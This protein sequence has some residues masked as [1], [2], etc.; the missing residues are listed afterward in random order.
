MTAVGLGDGHVGLPSASTKKRRPI[1]GDRASNGTDSN[2][3]TANA[4]GVMR[5]NTFVAVDVN[6]TNGVSGRS[7]S[8]ASETQSDKPKPPPTPFEELT[9]L[10]DRDIESELDLD[11]LWRK[12]NAVWALQRLP[13]PEGI[14]K[15]TPIG[16]RGQ[17]DIPKNPSPDITERF[18]EVARR[19]PKLRATL[20]SNGTARRLIADPR[21]LRSF[22]DVA[23]GHGNGN[24]SIDDVL[25]TANYEKIAALGDQ[26]NMKALSE[27]L[28][29]LVEVRD[30][31]EKHK[32]G[33]NWTPGCDPLPLEPDQWESERFLALQADEDA[34]DRN[35]I[36]QYMN[37]YGPNADVLGPFVA[38]SLGAFASSYL[39]MTW[40]AWYPFFLVVCFFTYG[41][42]NRASMSPTV[43][44]KGMLSLSGAATVHALMLVSGFQFFGVYVGEQWGTRMFWCLVGTAA[45]ATTEYFFLMTYL[46]GPGFLPK[47]SDANAKEF[48]SGNMR[49]VARAI[50]RVARGKEGKGKQ[51]EA[52]D[53]LATMTS[54]NTLAH[55]GRYCRTCHTART[56]RSKH[57]PFCDRCVSRMDH[58]CPIAGTCIGVRNQRHFAFALWDMTASQCIFLFFSYLHLRKIDG[59]WIFGAFIVEPWAIVLFLIQCLAMPYCLLLAVRMSG[60]IAF[61]LTV[62]EMENA[63]RYEYLQ[64][65]INEGDLKI[66]EIAESEKPALGFLNPFDRGISNNCLEFWR[67]DQERV[68]WDAQRAAVVLGEQRKPPKGSYSWLHAEDGTASR[69]VPPA[70]RRFIK[71]H[72]SAKDAAD[73]VKRR[74]AAL[75][76][77]HGHS[78]DGK[79][80]DG[81]HGGES[82]NNASNQHSHSHGGEPCDGD[83]GNVESGHG[84]G[85]E[86]SGKTLLRVRE[87]TVVARAAALLARA[88]QRGMSVSA[89]EAEESRATSDKLVERAKALG[90]STEEVVTMDAETTKRDA[91]AAG[92][93]VEQYAIVKES[94]L[95]REE[96]AQ[97]VLEA[98][99]AEFVKA[100]QGGA[101]ES[102]S[103]NDVAPS[104]S[105][106]EEAT[107][108]FQPLANPNPM[109]DAWKTHGDKATVI[110]E[111]AEVKREMMQAQAAQA[112]V[113]VD[114]LEE[115]AKNQMKAMLAQQAAQMNVTVDEMEANMNERKA[116][117]AQENGMDVDEFE[118]RMQLRQAAMYKMQMERM[119]QM[120]QMVA[121]NGG[122]QVGAAHGAHGHG[123]HGHAHG[124]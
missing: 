59:F 84:H 80:C 68:D 123:A 7:D 71:V 33:K 103:A 38:L 86:D 74:E 20:D 115:M 47:A 72:T 78:H 92:L 73:R 70:V 100:R 77:G 54:L 57:C 112:G 48:W 5:E 65:P 26:K 61:N 118:A 114:E 113:S 17:D 10:A 64:E 16:P 3:T 24:R 44:R 58:H 89:L 8:K 60:A 29:V 34:A 56:L 94:A 101:H 22:L 91:A 106:A 81:D 107:N 116:Q 117:A 85:A 19:F 21:A 51:S 90:V 9:A 49:R 124:H 67:G 45:F 66:N 83:H 63:H 1:D 104:T 2:G 25:M 13:D 76:S 27:E 55:G 31:M 40:Y 69:I 43:T 52:A 46:L 96:E 35:I 36:H 42:L 120:Q 95:R 53:S 28:S 50:A 79:P 6:G 18:A 111:A 122:G 88:D 102:T 108:Y 110:A 11:S 12:Q 97:R 4:S 15:R 87:E 14:P 119:K 99:R 121:A 62:N 82:K 93:T 37:A 30:E 75:A 23:T 98:R 105:G 109:R 41:V 39:N 32:H